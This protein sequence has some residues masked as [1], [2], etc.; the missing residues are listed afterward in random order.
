VRKTTILTGK[1]IEK[2]CHDDIFPDRTAALKEII[3]AACRR[4]AVRRKQID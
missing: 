3:K 1:P 2:S 4:R